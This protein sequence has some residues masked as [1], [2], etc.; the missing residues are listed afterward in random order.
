MDKL[1]VLVVEDEAM[2][3]MYMKI[4]L[5]RHGY[6]VLKCISTGEAAVDFA[7][8]VKPDLVLMDIRLAGKMDGIEAALLILADTAGEMQFVF[9]TGYSDPDIKEKAMK[10]KPLGF[11]TKPV[12][13]EELIKLVDSFFL[14]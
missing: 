11:F 1:S 7:I 2:T 8:M 12:N 6:D 10:L 3:A 13:L 4:M 9:T 14:K 5:S